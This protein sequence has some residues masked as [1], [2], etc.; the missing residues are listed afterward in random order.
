MIKK[1]T[2]K[3]MEAPFG[4]QANLYRIE[5]IIERVQWEHICR[6]HDHIADQIRG[7][8]IKLRGIVGL[9]MKS[10]AISPINAYDYS[11]R[12]KDEWNCITQ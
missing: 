3:C 6:L 4:G 10:N 2:E 5:K 11:S 8:R 12:N 7:T 1:T 9:E